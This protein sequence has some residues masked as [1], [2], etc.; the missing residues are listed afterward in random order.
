MDKLLN[1]SPSSYAYDIKVD[2][3]LLLKRANIRCSLLHNMFPEHHLHVHSHTHIC[4]PLTKSGLI[5]GRRLKKVVILK[6]L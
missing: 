6:H 3:T 4:M 1:L 2:H 5:Q